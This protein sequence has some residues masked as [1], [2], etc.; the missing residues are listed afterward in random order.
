MAS[1]KAVRLGP[2]AV[3]NAAGNLFNPPTLTGG[4]NPPAT[5]T[6]SYYILRHIRIVNKTAGAVTFSGYIGATGG[7]A[8]GTEFLGTALSIAANSAYDWYGVLRLDVADF[9]TGLASAAT[10]LT[11]EAE[12]EI[13][14]V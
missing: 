6:N 14:V 7:S 1:N 8:A 12:G 3:A 2:V 11:I 9:L 10:S 13:G 5:S 4:V